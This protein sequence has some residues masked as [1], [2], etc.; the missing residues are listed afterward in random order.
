M[1]SFTKLPPPK[2]ILRII[3]WLIADI[4]FINISFYSAYLI[5]FKG[6]IKLPAFMPYLHLWPHIN[7]AHLIIFS[8]FRLYRYPQRLVKREL[9][10]NT[11]NAST[12]S[13][14]ASMS[15]VYTMR[16]FWGFMP[17]SVFAIALVF[18]IILIYGWRVFVRYDI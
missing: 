4:I 7:L 6:V 1:F 16:H 3:S 12:I 11:V 14:L 5:R 10:I 13:T 2:E 9:F 17:S 8:I 18:N 15:I